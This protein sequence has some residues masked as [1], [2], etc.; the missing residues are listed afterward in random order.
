MVNLLYDRFVPHITNKL[1]YWVDYFE[2]FNHA[3]CQ[4]ANIPDADCDACCFI[5]GKTHY[6]C[7]PSSLRLN[8]DGEA[9][10]VIID[11]QREVYN[12]HKRV[13]CIKV[14]CVHAPNGMTIDFFGP[15]SGRR[16]DSHML[17]ES[18][19]NDRMAVAQANNVRQFTVYGDAAYGGKHSHISRGF[20]GANVTPEE[21]AINQRMSA[22]RVSVEWGFQKIV[23][24]NAYIDF[25]KGQKLLLQ[26]VAK[27]FAV[28]VLLT[29]C[30]TCL[31]GS[32]T[33]SYFGVEPPLLED[34]LCA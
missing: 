14:Q 11:V 30:H 20:T 21:S 18:H 16:H 28:A 15:V 13:H 26:P 22:V 4:K 1:H 32:Q 29:N 3:L 6:I 17:R 2:E 5:D 8:V 33:S 25:K 7:R 10:P 19:L 34:Y 27:Y 31:Y 12:G 23:A 24:Q 9:R